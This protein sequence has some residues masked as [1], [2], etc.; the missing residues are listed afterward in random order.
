M[1]AFLNYQYLEKDEIVISPDDRGFLFSDGLYEVVRYYKG[2]PF[3]IYEH[4]ERLEKGARALKFNRDSFPE[5]PHIAQELQ[6]KNNLLN[7]ESTIVYFQVTRGVAPRSHSFPKTDTPLTIYSFT[8]EFP[9]NLSEQEKGAS[10]ITVPDKRW[11]RCDI[12]SISLLANTLAH[13]EARDRGAIEALFVRDG[14]VQEGSH[15]NI[16]IFSNGRVRTPPVSNFILEG[17]TRRAVLTLCETLR[18]HYSEEPVNKSD[19]YQAEEVFIVGTTVEITPLIR[20]DKHI[21]GQNKPG[22]LTRRLQHAFR[23][24]TNP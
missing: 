3:R 16:C 12:K 14:S 23:E 2:K 4:Q 22:P 20:I 13:Q 19:L 17:I 15:S 5:F 11:A 24:L 6:I 8:R 10:A 21:I 7:A 18:I 9:G 1:I